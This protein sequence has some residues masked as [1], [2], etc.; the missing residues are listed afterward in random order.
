[1]SDIL[2]ELSKSSLFTVTHDTVVVAAPASEQDLDLIDKLIDNK[3]QVLRPIGAGGMGCVYLARHL[4]LNKDVALKTFTSSDLSQEAS[5]RFARE[6]KAIAKLNH[7]NIIQVFD[8]G[9]IDGRVPYYTMEY[10][11][12]QSLG[13]RLEKEKYLSIEATL[14]I[15]TQVFAG[16]S[17]AHK[18]NIVHRDMKPDNI[19]LESAGTGGGR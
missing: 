12:G 13:Q 16:L 2:H 8:F 3:Y 10:L 11:I 14:A 4:M 18:K 1:M 19:F 7:P 15:F 5:L 9:H 6:A 17:S